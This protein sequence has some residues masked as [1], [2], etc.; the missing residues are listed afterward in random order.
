MI[1]LPFKSIISRHRQHLVFYT[2]PGMLINVSTPCGMR[3]LNHHYNTEDKHNDRCYTGTIIISKHA[4]KQTQRK[5]LVLNV[6][7]TIICMLF[8]TL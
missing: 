4:N 1:P 3:Y 5:Q 8:A 6:K 2:N 7:K